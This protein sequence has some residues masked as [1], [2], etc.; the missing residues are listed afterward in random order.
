MW[1]V[2]L[3]VI[4]LIITL[5]FYKI[6]G[7]FDIAF[8]FGVILFVSLF[9]VTASINDQRI[10]NKF[11]ETSITYPTED[12]QPVYYRKQYCHL[13][14]LNYPDDRRLRL[15]KY[16][17]RQMPEYQWSRHVF[18]RIDCVTSSSDTV[19]LES[20]WIDEEHLNIT[21]IDGVIP[22]FKKVKYFVEKDT[23]IFYRLVLPPSLHRY[24]PKRVMGNLYLPEQ[25]IIL[26]GVIPE[27]MEY[28]LVE[29]IEKAGSI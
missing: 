29:S 19:P 2:C 8:F 21:I 11:N 1:V 25:P 6:F 5:V 17:F 18:Y 16:Q 15:E 10:V 22:C 14:Q 23:P 9:G 20:F 26:N 27:H 4:F 12:F 28:D 13:T 7:I 3:I 24:N